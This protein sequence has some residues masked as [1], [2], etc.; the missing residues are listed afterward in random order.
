MN[1]I[2]RQSEF[3]RICNSVPIFVLR[4][5]ASVQKRGIIILANTAFV[6]L[7]SLK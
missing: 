6:F 4:K 5:L 1:G 3:L 7:F 2:I